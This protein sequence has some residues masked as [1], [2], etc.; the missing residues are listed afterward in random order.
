MDDSLMTYPDLIT[1]TTYMA[2]TGYSAGEVA[3]AVEKPF[4]FL[5]VLAEAKAAERGH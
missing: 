5:D 3:Y 4:K 1:L 2:E